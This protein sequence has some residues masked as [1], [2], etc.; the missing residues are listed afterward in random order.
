MRRTRLLLHQPLM[1]RL[2]LLLVQ[3]RRVQ[4]GQPLAGEAGMVGGRRRPCCLAAASA[5][6][7]VAACSML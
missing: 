6:S 7:A 3:L 2:L 1:L 4:R 5:A